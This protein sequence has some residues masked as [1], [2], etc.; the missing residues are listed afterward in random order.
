METEAEKAA[1]L[2]RL[3]AARERL[4]N[5]LVSLREAEDARRGTTPPKLTL[6]HCTQRTYDERLNP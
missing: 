4:R 1:R 6:A 3:A 5:A 2:A